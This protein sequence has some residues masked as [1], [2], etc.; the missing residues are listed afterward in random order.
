MFK[1]D[2]NILKNLL[3]TLINAFSN[4]MRSSEK[5]MLENGLHMETNKKEKGR[6]GKTRLSMKK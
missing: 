2:F 1:F 4:S 3:K 6:K 5:N